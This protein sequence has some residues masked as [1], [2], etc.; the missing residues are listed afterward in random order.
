MLKE[1]GQLQTRDNRL[2]RQA[3]EQILYSEMA[4]VSVWHIRLVEFSDLIL[5]EGFLAR[6]PWSKLDSPNGKV[7]STL[8]SAHV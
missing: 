4:S 5:L 8:L 6:L 7:A 2:E 3:A 1:L